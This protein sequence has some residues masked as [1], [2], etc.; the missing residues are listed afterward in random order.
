MHLFHRSALKGALAA[1]FIASST[2]ALAVNISSGALAGA[3]PAAAG[4]GLNGSYW[5]QNV[6]SNA[7]ADGVFGTTP[8]AT[9]FSPTQ[10]YGNHGSVG[11][12]DYTVKSYLEA[13]GS[14]ILTGASAADSNNLSGA[15]YRFQGYIN[16]TSA[17]DTTPGDGTIDVNFLVGSDDGMRLKIGGQTVTE[18]DYARGFDYSYGSASFDSAG[19]YAIEM[20]YWENGGGTGFDFMWQTGSNGWSD[21]AASALYANASPSVPEPGTLALLALAGLGMARRRKS[22]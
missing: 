16:I 11:D 12:G 15:L 6:S 8:T 1:L 19:L 5:S 9:F 22:A 4:T 20:V 13:F 21:V 3:S 2:S 18:A 14:T 10:D 17:M 7:Q